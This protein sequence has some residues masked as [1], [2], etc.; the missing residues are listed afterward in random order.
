[1]PDSWISAV[2][3][4]HWDPYWNADTES[5]SLCAGCGVS[6]PFGVQSFLQLTFFSRIFKKKRQ[7][8]LIVL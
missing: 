5:V 7:I 6:A 3:D 4:R 1:M 2:L 8:F